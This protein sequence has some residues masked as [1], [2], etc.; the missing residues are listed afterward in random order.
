MRSSER[1]ASGRRPVPAFTPLAA[2][3]FA[4][5]HPAA[6]A[7]AQETEPAADEQGQD[8]E[9]VITGSRIR[10]DT[11]TSAAPMDVVLTESAK[12]KGISDVATM[13]Q[14]TTVAAG[15]PQVTS[16]IS[17]VN[18]VNGGLGTA[19]IS[20]RG[21]GENRTLLLVNGRRAGPSGVQ[22]AVSSFDLNNIPL[23]ARPRRDPEGRRV[24]DLRLGCHRGRGEHL[25][26]QGRRRGIQCVLLAT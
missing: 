17:S 12:V 18:V 3:V 2:A 16:V 9:L 6:G 4:V 25:H 19:T 5:L 22:G 23:V 7:L 10:K 14:S 24:V 13:L 8:E 15:S 21:L 11:F 1:S 20:L 26:A